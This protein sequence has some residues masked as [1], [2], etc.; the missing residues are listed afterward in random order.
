MLDVAECLGIAVAHVLAMRMMALVGIVVTAAA[1]AGSRHHAATDQIYVASLRAADSA[2]R[3]VSAARASLANVRSAWPVA[4]PVQPRDPRDTP[5]TPDS[6][7]ESDGRRTSAASRDPSPSAPREIASV[8]S[9][10]PSPAPVVAAASASVGA[11]TTVIPPSDADAGAPA[12]SSQSA[13]TGADASP[14]TPQE[15]PG[16]GPFV[17]F[18]RIV[19]PTPAPVVSPEGGTSTP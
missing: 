16:P 5:D 17:F 2:T 10:T 4:P 19:V 1:C 18:P 13:T 3:D 8:S 15:W 6:M 14:A 12:A 9:A 7:D 11:S